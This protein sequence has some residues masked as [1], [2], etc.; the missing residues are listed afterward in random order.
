MDE[1]KKIIPALRYNWLTSLYDPIMRWT[2]REE[3]FKHQL[4]TQA[5]IRDRHRVLDLGCGTGTLTLLIKKI[6]PEAKVDGLDGDEKVLEIARHKMSKLHSDIQFVHGFS[7]ELPYP[8]NAFD[9]VISSLMFHHLT[10]EDKSKTL[11][12]VYRVLRPGGELHIADWGKTQNA[13]MRTAFFSVQLLDGFLTT[14]DHVTGVF[15]EL[16][17]KAGFA[18]VK[19][20]NRFMTVYGTLSLYSAKKL[21]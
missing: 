3:T 15:P 20:E 13:I 4:V 21:D 5:N 7:F 11:H 16:I 8:E 9:R 14:T 18:D 10:R 17:R 1:R 2:M 19:E 12:E 6:H